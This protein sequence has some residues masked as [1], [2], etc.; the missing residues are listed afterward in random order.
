MA[1]KR[2]PIGQARA[3]LISNML[4]KIL[5]L[6]ESAFSLSIRSQ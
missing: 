6:M 5:L 3:K 2:K 4:T 1:N